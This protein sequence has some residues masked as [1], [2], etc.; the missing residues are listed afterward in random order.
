MNPSLG[1]QNGLLSLI[2]DKA[3]SGDMPYRC[4][5]YAETHVAERDL[6]IALCCHHS[7]ASL[8]Y[9]SDVLAVYDLDVN[10]L[11]DSA[12]NAIHQQHVICIAV[13]AIST[14]QRKWRQSWSWCK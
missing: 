10:G 8:S 2:C 4:M 7:S 1:S 9:D 14:I 3:S 11:N 13:L 6:P 5:R 12:H